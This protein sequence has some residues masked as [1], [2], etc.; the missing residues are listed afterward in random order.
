MGSPPTTCKSRG[1]G[2]TG[3]SHQPETE[4]HQE[5]RAERR[6]ASGFAAGSLNPAPDGARLAWSQIGDSGFGC[7]RSTV[8]PLP[9]LQ[10]R[11][12]SLPP[13]SA[14]FGFALIRSTRGY[15]VS[16]LPRLQEGWNRKAG[17]GKFEKCRFSTKKNRSRR[18]LSGSDTCFAE[19]SRGGPLCGQPFNA[20]GVFR[21]SIFPPI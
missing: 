20:S 9:R 12:V 15:L 14:P 11:W 10:V 4:L 18:S 8:S 3:N 17:C 6:E 16:P 21:N 13:G 7:G 1:S 2:D 19:F 5:R